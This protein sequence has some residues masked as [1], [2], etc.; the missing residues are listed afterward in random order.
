MVDR[1]VVIH[2]DTRYVC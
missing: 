2:F 1:W